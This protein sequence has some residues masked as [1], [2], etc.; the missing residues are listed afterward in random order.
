MFS[1]IVSKKAKRIVCSVDNLFV[2]LLQMM[3]KGAQAPTL[4]HPFS[5]FFADK[6]KNYM[7]IHDIS[8]SLPYCCFNFHH[9]HRCGKSPTTTSDDHGE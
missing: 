7:I 1:Q 8:L 3:M 4:W 5:L 2:F 9:H 6:D